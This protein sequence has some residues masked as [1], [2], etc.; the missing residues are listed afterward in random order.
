[1]EPLVFYDLEALQ[2]KIQ[3]A[4]NVCR[5]AVDEELAKC[6]TTEPL[7]QLTAACQDHADET[8]SRPADQ[9]DAAAPLATSRQVDFMCH[10]ARQIRSLGCQRLKL[11]AQQLYCRPIEELT[12]M[13]AS[14]LIDLLKEVRAG[15]RSVDELL[16]EVAA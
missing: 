3:A 12:A 11:L 7:S 16:P 10:L 14:R 15:T 2:G 13:E 6:E 8:A 4:F 1:M 9:H 5:R